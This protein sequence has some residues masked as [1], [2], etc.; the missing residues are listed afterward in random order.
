[1]PRKIANA[2]WVNV[3]GRYVIDEAGCWNWQGNICPDGYGKC[4]IRAGQS[5]A[6]RAFYAIL[7]GAIVDGMEVDHLCRN[8]RCVNPDH[9][10][11]VTPRVNRQRAICSTPNH[12]NKR[13]THC[14]SGH[15]LAGDNIKLRRTASGGTARRCLAC[16]KVQHQAQRGGGK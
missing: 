9:L 16:Q 15:L 5:L 3:P 7:R 12:R 11:A 2:D 14:P 1:M 6:H 13:K 8:R 10:E 4:G